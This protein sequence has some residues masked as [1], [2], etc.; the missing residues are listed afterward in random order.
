MTIENFPK[1][2]EFRDTPAPI[3]S[4]SR[5]QQKQQQHRNQ[6]F[7]QETLTLRNSGVV[8]HEWI[9]ISIVEQIKSLGEIWISLKEDVE[10]FQNGAWRIR[11][12]SDL[13]ILSVSVSF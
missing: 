3:S 1:V 7:I 9:L 2:Q 13:S 5:Y 6:D 12:P 8:L 4:T 11:P 10:H